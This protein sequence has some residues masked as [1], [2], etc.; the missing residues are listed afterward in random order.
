MKV[1]YVFDASTKAFVETKIVDEEYQLQSNET[2][3]APIS[4]D[5]TGLYDP[6]WNG[7]TWSSLTKEEWLAK[8]SANDGPDFI[9]GP[10]EAEQLQAQQVVMIANLTKQVQDLQG[11]VKTLV[12][13]NAVAN[14]EEKQM[15]TY[16]YSFVNSFYKMGLFTKDDVKLLLE[17]KQFSQDDYNK[18]FPD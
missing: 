6:V 4:E 3:V 14:K 7:T 2:L 11:A 9:S 12:L 1:V 13:Q 10:T 5:G 16:T 15:Y 8:Q 17:V 18:M